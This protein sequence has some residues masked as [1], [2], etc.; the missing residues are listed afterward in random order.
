MPDL[1]ANTKL[2]GG[3]IQEPPPN[4]DATGLWQNLKFSK[5]R[6]KRKVNTLR[7]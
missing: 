3:G 2:L 7:H 1:V 4:G 5:K 6:D